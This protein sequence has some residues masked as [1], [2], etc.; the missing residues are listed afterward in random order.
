M[1]EKLTLHSRE[2]NLKVSFAQNVVCSVLSTKCFF[3]VDFMFITLKEKLPLN[4]RFWGK[5]LTAYI[6]NYNT[7]A[8]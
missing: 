7:L 8:T 5:Y 4:V 1:R 6:Y 2:K 3:K